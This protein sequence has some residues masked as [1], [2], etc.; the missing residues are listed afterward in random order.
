M[1]S[2]GISRATVRVIR[3]DEELM[4]A[5]SKSAATRFDRTT[6]PAARRRLLIVRGYE[7]VAG[8]VL[9]GTVDRRDANAGSM[10]MLESPA[11]P[12]STQNDRAIRIQPTEHKN[13]LIYRGSQ[14]KHHHETN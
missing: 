2:S 1:I 10:Q 7:V 4:I 12:R 14:Q 5:H 8:E 6:S 13:I 9:A 3:A 11:F